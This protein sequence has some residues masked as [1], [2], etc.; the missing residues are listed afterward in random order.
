MEYLLKTTEVSCK[1]TASGTYCTTFENMKDL[2]GKVVKNN[3]WYETTIFSPHGKT[4]IHCYRDMFSS[5]VPP[6]SHISINHQNDNK[7]SS[8]GGEYNDPKWKGNTQKFEDDSSA[9][10]TPKNGGFEIKYCDK[11]GVCLSEHIN[12]DGISNLNP[13]KN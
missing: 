11:E 10:I 5:N 13:F 9:S 1:K 6:S 2:S 4:N 7:W 3:V 12:K 8:D